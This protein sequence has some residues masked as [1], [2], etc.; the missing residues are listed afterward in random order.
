MQKYF[1]IG[2]L[3]QVSLWDRHSAGENKKAYRDCWR[4]AEHLSS[5]NDS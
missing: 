5:V 2:I 4:E 1:E 3:N